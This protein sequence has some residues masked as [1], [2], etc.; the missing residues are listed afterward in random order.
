MET[1]LYTRYL[2]VSDQKTVEGQILNRAVKY[3]LES[4]YHEAGVLLNQIKGTFHVAVLNNRAVLNEIN[5]NYD[6]ARNYYHK[7]LELDS[8]NKVVLYNLNSMRY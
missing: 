8:G 5:G 1:F 6:E 7:A 2:I 4:S 3:I